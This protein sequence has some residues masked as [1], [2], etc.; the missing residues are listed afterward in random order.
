MAR[1]ATVDEY[2]EAMPEPLRQAAD[3]AR[4]VIDAH[5]DGASSAIKWSH[6]T[7]S[8]G[9]APVCYLK[10]ASNH[11]TVGFWR[12]ASIQDPSGRLETSGSVMAHTKLREPAN[13]DEELFAAWL[14]QAR[15]LELGGA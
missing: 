14:R 6:P 12:G 7:W 4:K 15:E 2:I 1:Y 9:K 10:R 8:L 5:L 11:V 13:V 3:A